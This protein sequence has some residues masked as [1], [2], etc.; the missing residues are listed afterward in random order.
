M[1]KTDK[2]K[3]LPTEWTEK[4]CQDLFFHAE[5]LGHNGNPGGFFLTVAWSPSVGYSDEHGNHLK[6]ESDWDYNGIRAW[7]NEHL[8]DVLRVWQNEVV[9][10]W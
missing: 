5:D 4:A 6:H 3:T 1:I 9:D 8:D 10:F 2:N 7:I